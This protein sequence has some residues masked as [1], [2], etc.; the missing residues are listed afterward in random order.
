MLQPKCVGRHYIRGVGGQVQ[1][2]KPDGYEK[3]A[4]MILQTAVISAFKERFVRGIQGPL[5]SK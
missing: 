5:Y 2:Y 1:L 4:E 3:A